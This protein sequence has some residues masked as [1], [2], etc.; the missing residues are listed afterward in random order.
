[1]LVLL[2]HPT[3]NSGTSNCLT[4]PL[5]M[6][7]NGPCRRMF[8]LTNKGR[9]HQQLFW[10]TEGFNPIK[11]KSRDFEYNPL[12][13]KYQVTTICL[14]QYNVHIYICLRPGICH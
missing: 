5:F 12:D 8:T 3:T 11:F 13:V 1:M 6:Y 14:V 2:S 4:L 9:R 7:S 10:S